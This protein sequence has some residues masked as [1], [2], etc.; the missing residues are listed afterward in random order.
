MNNKMKRTPLLLLILAAV[1]GLAATT[2]DFF[3][4][5]ELFFMH[6]GDKLNLHLLSGDTFT[7]DAEISYQPAKTT[8]FM[9]YNGSKKI[10]LTKA[11]K[12]S[13]VPVLNYEMLNSGQSLIE[14]TRGYEFSFT[15]RDSYAEFL[16]N[17]GLDK[18]AEKVKSG[19]Q[20]RVKEKYTRYLK[21]LVSVDNTDG[22][23]YKKELNEDFEVILKQNPYKKRYGD[24]M[25]A[26]L[27]FKGKP[28]AA[29]AMALYIKTITG[30]VYTQNLTTSN[31]GEVTFNLSREGVYL[32]RSVKIEPTKDKDAD[33]ESWWTSFTFP[34]SS[35][36]DLPNTYKEFGFG[37]KH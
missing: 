17:Q 1:I 26:V 34:F 35:S 15:S 12:D 24:D 20:F 30:N 7:K 27:K 4:L 22:D 29:A 28:V 21:T 6:K 25:V 36:E 31:D 23:A 9:L 10:D 13:A 37:N 2:H 19:N 5:P 32:L 16:N 14:M 18:M 3:L 8:R 33:Y 11:A